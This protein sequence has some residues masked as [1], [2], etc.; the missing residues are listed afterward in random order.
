MISS[1]RATVRWLAILL[2]SLASAAIANAQ[3]VTWT[4]GGDGTT[5]SQAANWSS[6]PALP[7]AAN[8]VIIPAGAQAITADISIT[9]RSLSLDRALNMGAV[10]NNLTISNGITLPSAAGVL[11]TIQVGCNQVTFNGTQSITGAGEIAVAA[12]SMRVAGTSTLTVGPGVTIRNVVGLSGTITLDAGASLLNQGT[13]RA[14]GQT[15][16][17]S[18]ANATS[19]LTNSG[20]LAAVSGGILSI[21]GCTWSN[22]GTLLVNAGTLN[23]GGTFTA[24]G[25]INRTAG[26]INIS[27][28]YTGAT[29][30]ISAATG[31]IILN[32]GTFTGTT[33]TATGGQTFSISQ[34]TTLSGVTVA[35]PMNLTADACNTLTVTNGLTLQGG[36]AITTAQVGC[37][38]LQ[39]S[40]PAQ[41]ITGAG[42]IIGNAG[43]MRIVGT[44]TLTIGP[45]V[46]LRNGGN[47]T[48][49][50]LDAGAALINQGT[51]RGTGAGL[52]FTLSGTP[53]STFTNSGSLEAVNSGTLSIGGMPW[54]NGGTVVV[55]TSGTA[56]LGGTLAAIGTI[57]RSGGTINLSGNYT[58]ANLTLS[59]ATGPIIFN[60]ITF[61]GTTLNAI[62][63]Q[64]FGVNSTTTLSGVTLNAP[65]TLGNTTCESL[66]ITNGLT[67]QGGATITSAQVGC[68]QIT[69]SGPPQS[70]TGN[71]SIKSNAGSMRIAGT[72]TLT[73]GPG[74]VLG[75]ATNNSGISLDAGASLINQGTIRADGATFGVSGATSAS[76]LTNTGTLEAVNNGTLNL[77]GFTWANNGTIVV[78]T[79]GTIN[80]GGTLAAIG[81]INRS[82]GTINLTGNY[83]GAS[84]MLS[85]ATGPINFGGNVTFTGTT[86]S[87]IDGQ[88][89]GISSGTTFSG[90]TLAAPLVLSNATCNALTITNGLTLQGGATI[91][92]A[93]VGCVQITFSGPSQS[94]NGTGT[95]A[96]NG[97]GLRLVGAAIL[98]IGPGIILR[99]D[100]ANTNFS[101]DD[102]ATL[103]NQG[104]IRASGV[105]RT[106]SISGIPGGSSCMLTNTGAIEA[107]AGGVISFSS[108]LV[109]TNNGQI[110]IDPASTVNVG[111]T[112]TLTLGSSGRVTFRINGPAAANA[113]R[114]VNNGT[115]N[116]GGAVTVAYVDGYA[117]TSCTPATTVI[118]TSG[119]G[120]NATGTFT[121]AIVPPAPGNLRSAVGYVGA[122]VFFAFTS[123]ADVAALGGALTP[124]GQLTADDIIAFLNA[125]FAGNLAVADV[126]G[127]GGTPG[128]DGQLTP[129]DL[130][131]FLDSFFAGCQ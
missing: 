95:I 21:T 32:G 33:F 56:N 66:I 53:T 38:Q 92:T 99:T 62:D 120:A 48:G 86:L 117:P 30:A 17:I 40:G 64:S 125:F 91:T 19:T 129:D 72:H 60:A 31:P 34:P 1:T 41:S 113:G 88:I 115:L 61:T 13:I 47:N 122:D 46:T 5:W 130:I 36:A 131:V 119:A 2:V 6:N 94:I 4:G 118:T 7:G 98:T 101:L 70:I 71:G 96:S 73:I 49:L 79:G 104:T 82:G 3:T 8:D 114:I 18:G 16:S 29:L 103:I 65:L 106:Y 111:P 100:T 10:C 55:N 102:G 89:F 54:S 77:S 35:A 50:S 93:Q 68:N 97:G 12:G 37:N 22:A 14:S 83:T 121:G 112:V 127:L 23:L 108:D 74:V 123:R 126:A 85:N 80:M 110:F 20:T 57:S 109:A 84:L 87:A 26:T 9:I 75:N 42:E 52:N 81:A 128:P 59:N 27:G 124:D 44:H 67:L 51:I 28:A 15:F 116:L 11:S 43:S 39:F 107:L 90:V 58:G 45:G 25:A 24:L 69:F 78:N 76:T 105:G 63:G